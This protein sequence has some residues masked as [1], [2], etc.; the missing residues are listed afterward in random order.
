VL[1]GEILAAF[2]SAYRTQH[3]VYHEAEVW[4]QVSKTGHGLGQATSYKLGYTD[5]MDDLAD[6][7][8][9]RQAATQQAVRQAKGPHKKKRA[10]A[11]ILNIK[12]RSRSYREGLFRQQC[13]KHLTLQTSG[14]WDSPTPRHTGSCRSRHHGAR[15]PRNS[16]TG[17]SNGNGNS[18]TGN[19]GTVQTYSSMRSLCSTERSNTPTDQYPKDGNYERAHH[20]QNNS[21]R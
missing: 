6:M 11:E 9:I 15:L 20:C 17:N 8:A 19:T 7:D 5:G 2:S 4:A 12:Y 13:D 18:G 1:H 14:E 21:R 10:T 3:H 16:G